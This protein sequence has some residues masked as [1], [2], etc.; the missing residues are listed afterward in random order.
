[1]VRRAVEEIGAPIA[2]VQVEYHPYL[3]QS[4]LLGYLRRPDLGEEGAGDLAD[5]IE[6]EVA[7]EQTLGRS[8][9]TRESLLSADAQWA[10]F[11]RRGWGL[12]TNPSPPATHSRLAETI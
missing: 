9:M 1:M 5:R 6:P 2:S 11:S 7:T 3:S 10:D 8:T 12:C 4:A